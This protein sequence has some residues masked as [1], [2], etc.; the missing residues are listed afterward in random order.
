MAPEPG[1]DQS[2]LESAGAGGGATPVSSE[3]EA[4]VDSQVVAEVVREAEDGL[5]EEDIVV[6]P[7]APPPVCPVVRPM[8]DFMLQKGV[9]RGRAGK[10]RPTLL[11]KW[12]D[13]VSFVGTS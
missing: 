8:P 11:L 3:G 12:L 2:E 1:S 9:A 4:S 6:A 7:P 5:V 13:T 10:N